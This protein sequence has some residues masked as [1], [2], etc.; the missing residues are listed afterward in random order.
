M[1]IGRGGGNP[2]LGSLGKTQKSEKSKSTKG[3]KKGTKATAS[4]AA[5]AVAS[6]Q[7]AEPADELDSPIYDELLSAANQMNEDDLEEATRTVVLAV[8]REQFGKKGLSEKEMRD[9]TTAVSNS[10]SGD[11]A[12]QNRLESVLKRISLQAK[13]K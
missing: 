3:T 2:Y 12:L 5:D 8:I 10:I 13:S 9:I 1:K 7:S 6:T 11:G 4:T